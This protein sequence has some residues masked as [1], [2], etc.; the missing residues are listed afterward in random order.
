MSHCYCGYQFGYF[1]GQ[2]G[3]GR[4]VSLGD[5]SQSGESEFGPEGT[6]LDLQL[7]GAGL[8]PY[9]RTA[10]GRA[11]LRSS[12]REFLAS[13]A[14]HHLGVPTTRA[15]SLVV[16]DQTQVKRDKLYT[17]NVELEKCCVVMR[18]APTFMR[19]GSFEVFLPKSEATKRNGPSN[20]L[21]DTM[22]QPML[23]YLI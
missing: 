4:A 22:L 13:E 11:V 5:V 3:D 15:A 6:L 10:D 21:K 18:V 8:T 14:M 19:F 12:V 9:S 1:S 7:K 20:G 17:G 2:L 16:S 23:D